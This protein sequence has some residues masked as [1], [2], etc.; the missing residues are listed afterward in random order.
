MPPLRV[1]EPAPGAGGLAPHAARL[2]LLARELLLRGALALELRLERLK[3]LN[4]A[5]KF[6]TQLAEKCEKSL[7]F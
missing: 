1:R 3:I 6:G 4:F 2:G 7:D 5:R